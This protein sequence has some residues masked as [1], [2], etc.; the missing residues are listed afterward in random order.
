MNSIN[1]YVLPLL[2]GP[3][4]SFKV[5]WYKL[6]SIIKKTSK[7]MDK[8]HSLMSSLFPNL[9]LYLTKNGQALRPFVFKLSSFKIPSIDN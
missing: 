9:N 7:L 5:L 8:E 1:K 6:K 2:A 3:K 4:E